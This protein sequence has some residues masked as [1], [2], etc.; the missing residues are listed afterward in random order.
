MKKKIM[1]AALTTVLLVLSSQT[2]SLYADNMENTENSDINSSMEDI[3]EDNFVYDILDEML[4]ETETIETENN[5][6]HWSLPDLFGSNF[7]WGNDEKNQGHY[8]SSETA[9]NSVGLDKETIEKLRIAATMPDKFGQAPTKEKPNKFYNKDK[10]ADAYHGRGNYVANISY[11]WDLAQE[12]GK[13]GDKKSALANV[14]ARTITRYKSKLTAKDWEILQELMSKMDLVLSTNMF[15]GTESDKKSRKYKILGIAMHMA[16]DTCAHRT[17]V[18]KDSINNFSS[19]YFDEGT[20]T[21]NVNDL[22]LWMK[23][24]RETDYKNKIKAA[25]N[26]AVFQQGVKTGCMEFR[27]IK[28]FANKNN[29]ENIIKKYEDK[30]S[31]YSIRYTITKNACIRLLKAKFLS[32]SRKIMVPRT[33]YFIFNNLKGYYI[34]AGGSKSDF[35]YWDKISTTEFV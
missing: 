24:G 14:K 5:I 23:K 27:D 9:G 19:S 26:W 1:V 21:V 25:A 31:F 22:K 10:V 30:A 4:E 2:T 17:I 3:E 6:I 15:P 35:N 34:A 13:N 7:L 28:Y 18:P 16:G 12:L 32:D 33:H 29:I 20:K 11:M 8:S